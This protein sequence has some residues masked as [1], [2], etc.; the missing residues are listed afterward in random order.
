MSYNEKKATMHVTLQWLLPSRVAAAI[1]TDDQSL[2]EAIQRGTAVTLNVRIML[3][4]RAGKTI[5]LWT[6]DHRGIAVNHET[7]VFA[8]Q[9]AAITDG[10]LLPVLFAS[11]SA[12]ICLAL[13]HSHCGKSTSTSRF[14]MI[15]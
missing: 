6:P 4:N 14:F 9:V 1:C 2:V 11:A 7:D 8:K 12:L 13:K 10:A 3:E 15:G 5:P